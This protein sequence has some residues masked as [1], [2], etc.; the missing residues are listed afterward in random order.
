MV[1]APKVAP[2]IKAVKYP[3]PPAPVA[4]QLEP[5][6]QVAGMPLLHWTQA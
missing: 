3:V 5:D 2:A 6:A 4:G 1:P